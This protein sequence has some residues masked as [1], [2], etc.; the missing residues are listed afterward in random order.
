MPELKDGLWFLNTGDSIYIQEEKFS[1]AQDAPYIVL[2]KILKSLMAEA[3]LG[4]LPPEQF[5]AEKI[6]EW[7]NANPPPSSTDQMRRWN[8]VL[9]R[10]AILLGLNLAWRGGVTTGA[11]TLEEAVERIK[12]CGTSL[13]RLSWPKHKVITVTLINADPEK[14]QTVYESWN[15]FLPPE[16][17]DPPQEGMEEYN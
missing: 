6:R 3:A 4:Q 16:L 12:K 14:C 15:S 11:A 5:N 7:I 13:G 10:Q 17:A 1:S 2:G 8:A 9:A